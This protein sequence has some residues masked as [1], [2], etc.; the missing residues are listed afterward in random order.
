[1]VS[2]KSRSRVRS[3][4]SI[5]RVIAENNPKQLIGIKTSRV[6]SQI[7]RM[8]RNPNKLTERALLIS[9]LEDASIKVRVNGRI[10]KK[11]PPYVPMKVDDIKLCFGKQ[12]DRLPEASLVQLT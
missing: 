11:D 12:F 10:I 3:N 5:I 2:S 1:M 7:A 8:G 6:Y 4:D 9:A